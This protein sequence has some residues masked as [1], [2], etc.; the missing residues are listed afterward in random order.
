MKN[1]C[2]ML[3]IYKQNVLILKL[4]IYIFL[5]YII[6]MLELLSSLNYTEYFFKLNM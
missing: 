6:Q 3:I 1:A 5:L 2:T 4:Y